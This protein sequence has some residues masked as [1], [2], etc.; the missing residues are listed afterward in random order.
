MTVAVPLPPSWVAANDTLLLELVEEKEGYLGEPEP[1][2]VVTELGDYSVG[3]TLPL[4]TPCGQEDSWLDSAAWGILF[5]DSVDSV[6]AQTLKVM[7]R[8]I[9]RLAGNGF[10]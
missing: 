7:L 2:V 3:V 4:D 9:P 5:G 8:N 10:E 1:S 6:D